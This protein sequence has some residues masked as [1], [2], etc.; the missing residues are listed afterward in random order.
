[1]LETYITHLYSIKYFRV[2]Y[3]IS[4]RAIPYLANQGRQ[5]FLINRLHSQIFFIS[6][7]LGLHL[8]WSVDSKL[9]RF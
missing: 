1:M 3:M 4:I 7:G 9:Q 2:I 8:F 5:H 6:I